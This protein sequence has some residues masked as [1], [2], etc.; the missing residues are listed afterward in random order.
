MKQEAQR[1]FRTPLFIATTLLGL[2]ACVVA[3]GDEAPGGAPGNG[4][5]AKKGGSGG[6]INVGKGGGTVSVG[7][8]SGSTSVGGS[9]SGSAG[10]ASNGSGGALDGGTACAVTTGQGDKE[11]VALLFM[12][13]ISGSM[14]CPIPE[15]MDPVCTTDPQKEFDNTRWKE[16]SPALKD[17][18]SSPQSAGMWAGISFFSRRNSCTADDYER[19]DA[20]IALLP[21]ASNGIN[22]A[23]DDQSPSGYTPTV[24]SLTGALDHAASW[25]RAHANQQV[26]VVYA[27]DGYPLG[28]DHDDRDNTID[29]AAAVAKTAYDGEN[30]IRTYV[31]GVGPN[32]TE[33]NKI[34]ASG[35]TQQAMLI[36]PTQD[37]TTQLAKQFDDI[38]NAVA[39]DCVYNV[40][41]PPAGQNFDGRVNV[42]YTSA[43]ADPA[44]VGFNDA[45]S[46]DEGWQYVDTTHQQI[47]LCGSTCDTVKADTSARIDVL[48]GCST[49]HVGDVR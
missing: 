45:A 37:L 23:I 40:P 17:F 39:I 38:R 1:H 2:I 14:R 16:M 41:A 43:G 9:T 11:E 42:N 25:A 46:C 33:L 10:S 35:G 5:D 32:L 24:A 21:N 8:S 44:P 34:A 13:D 15:Q 20:E 26:V 19:P 28:C 36:D 30:R 7:G 4:L 49:V 31:L 6:G 22:R 27:T 3:C 18:F 48:Y 29:L 47:K 12:V